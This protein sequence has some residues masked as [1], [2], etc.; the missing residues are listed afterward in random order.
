MT[1]MAFRPLLFL[2]MLGLSGAIGLGFAGALHPAFDTFAHFR[3]HF[4]VGLIALAAVW[5]FKCSRVPALV[6]AAIGFG[7]IMTCVP[8][9]AGVA[10][11]DSLLTGETVHRL[12]HVNVRYDNPAPERVFAMLAQIDAD[13]VSVNET[14][15]W[16]Q[17]QLRGRLGMY[18]HVYHCPEWSVFGGVMLFSKFPISPGSEFCGDYASLA[19]VDMTIDGRTVT[20]GSAHLRW[21]WPASGPR[22]VEALSP[23]L[24]ALGADALIAGDFNAATWSSLFRKFARLG[25][26]RIID[27]IGPTWM[28]RWFPE[29][30]IGFAGLPIDNVLAKGDIRVVAARSLD[31]V[32][33]DHL[34]VLVE[35]VVRDTECCAKNKAPRTWPAAP[36]F[37]VCSCRRCSRQQIPSGDG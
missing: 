26:L 28:H 8:G 19:L 18:A 21:P 10:T 33:S 35:F 15:D 9:F 27:G 11:R 12:V 30:L 32:G 7:A 29:A 34:P 17:A 13:I 24:G 23:R 31:P 3:L 6:F 14:S 1:V 20:I 2:A 37:S 25:N 5:T 16:W 36:E 4:S 22:Q